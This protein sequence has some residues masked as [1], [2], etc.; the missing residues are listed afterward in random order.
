[1][2]LVSTAY[3]VTAI[4][5]ILIIPVWCNLAII[6]KSLPDFLILLQAI[7]YTLNLSKNNVYCDIERVHCGSKGW[8]RVAHTDMSSHK[9]HCPS[10]FTLIKDP[11]C[12]CGSI[13]GPWCATAVFS[14]HD[15]SYSQQAER[16]SERNTNLIHL[17][18]ST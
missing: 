12:T 15:M 4:T 9:Q 10:N 18:R 8:T 5:S 7:S 1:M 6:K 13:L 16:I 11:I 2:Q 14:T 3:L 17:Q